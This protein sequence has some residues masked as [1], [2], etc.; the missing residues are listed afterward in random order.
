M[1]ILKNEKLLARILEEYHIADFFEDIEK[2][3]SGLKLITFSKNT[4]L[5]SRPEHRKYA[6]FLI[7]GKLSIYAVAENGKQMLVRYCDDFIFLG[8]MELLGYEEPSNMTET[9]TECL[10]LA[11]DMSL[12]RAELMQDKKFLR[13]LCGSLAEKISYFASMQFRN[14]A[15]SPQQKVAF[16]ILEKLE[17][18]YFK[19]N[20]RWTAELLDISYRHLHR[21]LGEFVDKGILVRTERGYK[22]EDMDAMRKIAHAKTGLDAQAW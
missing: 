11:L 9:V 4:F 21:I 18:G 6:Y 7:S 22:A 10:F 8:D 13:F 19:E 17:Q 15:G 1:E 20:L 12:M 3:K 14:R 16:H 5:Y 2:Y